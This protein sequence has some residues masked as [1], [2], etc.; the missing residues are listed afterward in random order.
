MMF[1]S[2]RQGV[3][4]GLLAV[5]VSL[6][7]A[8]VA[9]AQSQSNRASHG[10]VTRDRQATSREAEPVGPVGQYHTDIVE[11]ARH[12]ESFRQ[13]LYTGPRMQLVTMSVPAGSS[14]GREAHPHV[15][16]MLVVVSGTGEARFDGTRYPLHAG[17]V[18]VVQPGTHHD[19]ANTGNEPLRLYTVY[20]PPN[21]LPGTM[22]RTRADAEADRADEEFGNHVR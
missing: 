18:V 14:I 7:S 5:T 3:V 19:I 8:W 9:W 11:Q 13:V 2:G 1:S 20:T 22:H 21:H 6:T 15:E 10:A 12:N 4:V 16:Q 17:D